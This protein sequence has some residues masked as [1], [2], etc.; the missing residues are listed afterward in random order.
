FVERGHYDEP[1][2][3][4]AR[5]ADSLRPHLRPPDMDDGALRE[6]YCYL[7]ENPPQRQILRD[8]SLRWRPR[9]RRENQS[10][11]A[12]LVESITTVRNNLFHGGKELTVPLTERN[13][14]LVRAALRWLAHAIS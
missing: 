6:A 8:R 9:T 13:R 5:F 2:V 3:K 12:F 1:R 14:E 11:E 4:W 10:C 7:V